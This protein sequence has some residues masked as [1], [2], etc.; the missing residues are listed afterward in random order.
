M[1]RDEKRRK[2]QKK[3]MSQLT[4]YLTQK[5]TQMPR[6]RVIGPKK[7]VLEK[8][9]KC[10][11]EAAIVKAKELGCS[12]DICQD[13][14]EEFEFEKMIK[15]I[16]RKRGKES[17]KK[18]FHIINEETFNGRYNIKSFER[19]INDISRDKGEDR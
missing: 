16:C 18:F 3:Y 12:Q 17:A 9:I 14:I 15:T 11:R 4:A 5:E 19:W 2:A 7:Q 1:S 13:W 8:Y 10:G 6:P